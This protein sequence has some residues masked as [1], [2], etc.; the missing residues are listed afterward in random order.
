VT[1]LLKN[2]DNLGCPGL[3]F[4]GLFFSSVHLLRPRYYS[5]LVIFNVIVLSFFN[6]FVSSNKRHRRFLQPSV[7]MPPRPSCPRYLVPCQITHPPYLLPYH[8]ASLPRTSHS[9]NFRPLPILPFLSMADPLAPSLPSSIRFPF[10]LH[11][12]PLAHTLHSAS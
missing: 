9:P 10:I 4:L 3:G 5:L 2:H 11:S 8:H 6:Y 1:I 12:N 7:F